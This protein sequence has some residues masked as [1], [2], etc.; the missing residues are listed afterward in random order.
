MKMGKQPHQPILQTCVI[1]SEL[2]RKLKSA[3]DADKFNVLI[4][5]PEMNKKSQD[6]YI[7]QITKYLSENGY[8]E[9][10]DYTIGRRNLF[11]SGFIA[12]QHIYKL[13][14]NEYVGLIAQN[15]GRRAT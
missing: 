6:S 7:P 1:E 2:E 10:T 13:A 4:F 9:K 3:T 12:A 11:V 8:N 5:P 14:T 15:Q